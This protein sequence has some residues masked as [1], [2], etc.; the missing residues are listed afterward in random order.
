VETHNLLCELM[1]CDWNNLSHFSQIMSRKPSLVPGESCKNVA[2]SCLPCLSYFLIP[3]MV[4]G[5][6]CSLVSPLFVTLID[7][8][9]SNSSCFSAHCS[10]RYVGGGGNH[11]SWKRIAFTFN[12]YHAQRGGGGKADATPVCTTNRRRSWPVWWWC[13]LPLPYHHKS[14]EK[15]RQN[16]SVPVMTSGASGLVALGPMYVIGVVGWVGYQVPNWREQYIQ[17]LRF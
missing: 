17:A 12:H 2:A 8:L 5:W 4:A 6:G 1:L 16:C 7:F 15:S 11:N 13:I 14:Q 10:S 9:L 3:C